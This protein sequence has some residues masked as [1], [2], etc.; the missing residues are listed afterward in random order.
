MTKQSVAVQLCGHCG[1]AFDQIVMP[2]D[3]K[4]V[5]PPANGDISLCLNCGIASVYDAGTWHLLTTEEFIALSPAEK[6]T[7][8]LMRER[9]AEG[10]RRGIIGDLTRRDPRA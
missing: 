5:I 6:R 1:Y 4:T 7:L 2:E 10:K 3:D 8:G 9:H